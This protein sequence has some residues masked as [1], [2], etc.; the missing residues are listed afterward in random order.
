MQTHAIRHR[1]PAR[2]ARPAGTGLRRSHVGRPTLISVVYGCYAAFLSHD[3]GGSGT[4]ALVTGVVA[5]AAL[6]VLWLAV[7]RLLP[8]GVLRE[9]R[10]AVCGALAGS[11]FGVLADL[12]GATLGKSV[13]LGLVVAAAVAV[14]TN[15]RLY[16][17][18]P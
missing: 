15:Y 14:A 1:I 5:G 13:V 9:V 3:S 7:A 6:L 4:R 10:S 11:A 12:S 8:A 17:R 16:G 18:V 2:H